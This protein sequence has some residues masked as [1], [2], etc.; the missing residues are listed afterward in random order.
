[1]VYPLLIPNNN[2]FLTYYQIYS[3]VA[4]PILTLKRF[5]GQS[6]VLALY[7][8]KVKAFPV[9]STIKIDLP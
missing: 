1:M 5:F 4:L 7:S 2:T 9:L 8:K 3:C 6:T